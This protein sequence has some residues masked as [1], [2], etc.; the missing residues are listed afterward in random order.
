MKLAV[1]Y[2][3][4]IPLLFTCLVTLVFAFSVTNCA[5]LKACKLARLVLFGK[6]NVY[7]EW[8]ALGIGLTLASWSAQ[9]PEIDE[10]MV[11]VCCAAF[12]EEHRE[13]DVALPLQKSFP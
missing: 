8:V 2:N 13:E 7:C 12:A 1:L 11:G 4:Q 5:V 10:P 6:R 9:V 3:N